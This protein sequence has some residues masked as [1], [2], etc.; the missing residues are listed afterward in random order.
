MKGV[1]AG[2]GRGGRGTGSLPDRGGRDVGIQLVPV[3][4]GGRGTGSLPRAP[5]GRGGRGTGNL[6]GAPVGLGSPGT[7]SFPGAPVGRGGCGPAREAFGRGGRVGRGGRGTGSL[8]GASGGRGGHDTVSPDAQV[9]CG[10]GTMEHRSAAVAL[11]QETQETSVEE[12]TQQAQLHAAQAS[13][14]QGASSQGLLCTT[15]NILRSKDQFSASQLRK[16]AS[17]R[18]CIQCVT[19][20]VQEGR[21]ATVPPTGKS[22]AERRDTVQRACAAAVGEKLLSGELTPSNITPVQEELLDGILQE[23]GS[24]DELLTMLDKGSRRW[25]TSESQEAPNATTSTSASAS[26]ARVISE[27]DVKDDDQKFDEERVL[28][29]RLAQPFPESVTRLKAFKLIRAAFAGDYQRVSALLSEGA[30]VSYVLRAAD[31]FSCTALHAACDQGHTQCVVQLLAAKANSNMACSYGGA[32]DSGRSVLESAC[33]G[34]S[35]ECVELLLAAGADATRLHTWD[36]K[37]DKMK[38]GEGVKSSALLLA[39]CSSRSEPGSRFLIVQKLLAAKASP[40]A[41]SSFLRG[42]PL[43]QALAQTDKHGPGGAAEAVKI[44]MLLMDAGADPRQFPGKIFG[45]FGSHLYF[46]CG[47]ATYLMSADVRSSWL[48]MIQTMLDRG[49]SPEECNLGMEMPLHKAAQACSAE[50][51]QLLIKYS[52]AEAVN[53]TAPASG[54]PLTM[55]CGPPLCSSETAVPASPEHRLGAAKVL[56]AAGA[57]VNIPKAGTCGAFPL[58]QAVRANSSPLV[59]FLLNAKASADARIR[60][61]DGRH[62]IHEE[63]FD[64]HMDGYSPLDLALKSGSSHCGCAMVLLAAGATPPPGAALPML[65]ALGELDASVVSELQAYLREYFEVHEEAPQ[66][67]APEVAHGKVCSFCAKSSSSDA[68]LLK[69]EGCKRAMYCNVHC[70]TSHWERGHKNLCRQLRGIDRQRV[71]RERDEG[72]GAAAGSTVHSRR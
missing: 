37:W 69:C 20:A 59:R 17:S 1:G 51:L 6:P 15:C 66:W 48:N 31:N 71:E 72:R 5:A 8:P 45:M 26:A 64:S 55:A 34:G 43:I 47:V 24:I 38:G 28:P 46:A 35:P 60:A 42:T 21:S 33:S 32:P 9:G 23:F 50:V 44:A 10:S 12:A 29:E 11:E 68:K 54:T 39:I 70:Q 25:P 27:D 53:R 13:S 30:S 14:S 57:S 40:S 56:V 41:S 62:V 3:G 63:Q 18:R 19:C 52:S 61:S 58:H 2:A 49:V 4:R 65:G 67:A 36:L 22:L 7:S 16:P